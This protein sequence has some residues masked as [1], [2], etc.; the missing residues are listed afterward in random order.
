VAAVAIVTVAPVFF[1][2]LDDA[3]F[4]PVITEDTG[5][6]GCLLIT[7]DSITGDIDVTG[8]ATIDDAATEGTGIE[9]GNAVTTLPGTTTFV[10]REAVVST[11]GGRDDIFK[12]YYRRNYIH[13]VVKKI[14]LSI[15]ESNKE[16]ECNML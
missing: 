4:V 1:L 3:D 12:F 15:K 9:F 7:V 13:F 14:E 5:T 11:R 6:S 2:L 8:S 16:K 10:D